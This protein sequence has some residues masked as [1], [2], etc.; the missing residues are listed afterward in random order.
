[1]P[2]TR[3][4]RQRPLDASQRLDVQV[5]LVRVVFCLLMMLLVAV[6]D[7][8]CHDRP[9][10]HGLLLFVGL[11]YPH[12]GHL[13]SGRFDPD[14]RH[15]RLLF[16]L[17][18]LYAGAVIGALEF[19]WLPSFVVCVICLFNWLVVGGIPLIGLGSAAMLAGAL[20]SG[21]LPTAMS[22][23]GL[24]SGCTALLWSTASLF[25]AYFL[26]VAYVIHRLI[27]ALQHQQTILQANADA[28]DAAR[29]LA[30]RA[31]LAAFP[32]SVAKQ[33]EATGKHVPEPLPAA[34]LALIELAAF[35]TAP[36]DLAPLQATWDLCETILTRHGAELIKTFDRRAIA[37][38]RGDTGLQGLIDA[39]REILIHFSDHPVGPAGC[40]RRILIHRG[41]VTLGLVQ[42]ARLNLDFCGPG[43]EALLTLAAQAAELA[44]QGLIVSPAAF[45]QLR[46]SEAFVAHPSEVDS[47]LCYLERSYLE[48]SHFA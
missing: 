32:R 27:G 48:R 13:I 37:L 34:N 24:Q 36:Q 46:S 22:S 29:S 7:I 35:D 10:A 45:R 1:M 11:I 18:G 12:L 41:S 16:M 43:I 6:D 38:C 40:P 26:I 15:R 9:G 3:A 4:L 8:Y 19:A 28:A 42:P 20:L 47:P 30:E 31:L 2:R 44:L 33:L 21:S 5:Y 39:A 17:D 23:A 25:V 14:L